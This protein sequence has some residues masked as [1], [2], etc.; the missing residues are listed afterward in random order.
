MGCF[1]G[2]ILCVIVMQLISTG[3][4]KFAENCPTAYYG[5]R[6]ALLL[7]ALSLCWAGD[8][9]TTKGWQ[10]WPPDLAIVIAIDL[11]MAT[12]VLVTLRG[13]PKTKALRA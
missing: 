6:L 2:V 12:S 7:L 4:I 11:M 3:V 10:P 9:S 13:A 1:L 5:R 8:Y